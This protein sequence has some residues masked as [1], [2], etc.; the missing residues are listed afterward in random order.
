MRTA[1][2]VMMYGIAGAAAAGLVHAS[3]TAQIPAVNPQIRPARGQNVSPVYEGWFHGTDGQTYASFG[4]FNRN[5]EE[6][7][8]VPVGPDNKVEPGAADQG[9]P[10][11]F[12]PGRQFGVFAV[13]LPKGAA[14]ATWALTV[15][16]RQIAIPSN[17]D[18]QYFIE[19]LKEMGGAFPGNTPPTVRFAAAGPSVQGPA[20]ASV[21]RTAT[22]GA[23]IPLEIW[24]A[25][26]GLPP[27][28][29]G[30]APGA[31]GPTGAAAPGAP[32]AT[33]A[34]SAALGRGLSVTWS[35]FRGGGMA[36]FANATPPVEKGKASTTVTFSEP[37]EYMLRALVSDG[38]TFSAQCCWTNGYVKVTVAGKGGR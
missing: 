23:P 29:P 9:Q 27:P 30:R 2:R 35:Q 13:V 20:G 15:A 1:S 7:V 12:Q 24:V 8:Q 28:V 18:Q 10:T 36:T 22:M 4:Y 37:G 38:S 33:T 17:L 5:T 14:E 26:D 11:R 32:P 34:R 31:Q 16:G 25:D 21:T 19:P 6:V 3:L